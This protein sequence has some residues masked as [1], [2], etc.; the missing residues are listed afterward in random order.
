VYNEIEKEDRE[1]V[2]S[3]QQLREFLS[4]AE[5]KVHQRGSLSKDALAP[6]VKKRKRSITPPE[7]ITSEDEAKYIEQEERMA[8]RTELR[9]KSARASTALT[10]SSSAALA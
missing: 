3:A 8:K 9:S 10:I 6:G 5:V 4:A 1:L 2:I 7:E